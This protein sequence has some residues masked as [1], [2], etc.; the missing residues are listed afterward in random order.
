MTHVIHFM[1]Q[2]C[3]QV[4]V[5]AAAVICTYVHISVVHGLAAG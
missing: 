2:T 1:A 4:A 5:V 3:K